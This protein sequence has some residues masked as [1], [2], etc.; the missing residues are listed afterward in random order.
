MENS[1]L[2]ML[3]YRDGSNDEIDKLHQTFPH[4]TVAK[5]AKATISESAIGQQPAVA[6]TAKH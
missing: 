4:Q 5:V 6:I 2:R 1:R 3:S